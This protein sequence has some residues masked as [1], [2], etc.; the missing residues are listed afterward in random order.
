MPS[1]AALKFHSGFFGLTYHGPINGLAAGA[2]SIYNMDHP[3]DQCWLRKVFDTTC[4]GGGGGGGAQ[5]EGLTAERI[6]DF[7]RCFYRGRPQGA[8]LSGSYLHAF[9][10]SERAFLL[11]LLEEQE[12]ARPALGFDELLRALTGAQQEMAQPVPALEYSS[13]AL[14]RDDVVKG[15]RKQMGPQQLARAPITT[16]QE[17]G[18]EHGKGNNGADAGHPFHLETSAVTTFMD[19]ME[20]MASGRSVA[21]EFSAHAMKKLLQEGGFGMGV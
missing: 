20:K 21:G 7:L 9:P 15:T 5:G 19:A 6:D 2:L 11:S 17:V 14:L 13:S 16:S 3:R 10:P 18:W 1:D 8:T 4:G 12:A